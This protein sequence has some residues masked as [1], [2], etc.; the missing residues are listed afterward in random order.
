MALKEESPSLPRGSVQPGDLLLNEH[1]GRNQTSDDAD[2]APE[3][4]PAALKAGDLC[5]GTCMHVGV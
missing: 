5:K 2:I 3:P 1:C 4:A